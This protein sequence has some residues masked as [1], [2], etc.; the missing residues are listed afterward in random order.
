MANEPQPLVLE[1]RALIASAIQVIREARE[2]KGSS[3]GTLRASLDHVAWSDHLV[4]ESRLVVDRLRQVITTVAV[5]ERVNGAP[6]ERVIALLK[7]L[8]GEA[9]T[10]RIDSQLAR[11]LTEDI[12]RWGI[13][14]YYAA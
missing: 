1:A 5:S 13:E 9:D 11:S 6:P 12:V 2:R 14:G 4:G 8:V 7:R 3:T 10:K